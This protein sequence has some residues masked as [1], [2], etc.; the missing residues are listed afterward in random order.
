MYIVETMDDRG[1]TLTETWALASDGS[2]L[3]RE[4]NIIDGEKQLYSSRQVF[5]RE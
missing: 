2:E 1:A 5:D 3:I 4:I